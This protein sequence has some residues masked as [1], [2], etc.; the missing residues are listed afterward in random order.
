MQ[1]LLQLIKL[2]ALYKSKI[3]IEILKKK[4][5]YNE[6]KIRI[7]KLKENKLN[8]FNIEFEGT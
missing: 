3:H 8:T 6:L 7:K 4:E 1:F 2:K 5:I